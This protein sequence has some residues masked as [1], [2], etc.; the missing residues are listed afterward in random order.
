MLESRA[1][2]LSPVLSSLPLSLTGL[3][4][5]WGEVFCADPNLHGDPK[6]QTG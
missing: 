1:V 6:L 3:Q 2:G 4:G 5:V